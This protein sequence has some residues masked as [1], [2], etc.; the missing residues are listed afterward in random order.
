MSQSI[1][2]VVSEKVET[3]ILIDC[4]HGTNIPV[5]FSKI[6]NICNEDGKLITEDNNPFL[7]ECLE[8]I[9]DKDNKYYIDS[10]DTL[11]TSGIYL[12]IDTKGCQ[13][14]QLYKVEQNSNGD[15][16]AINNKQLEALDTNE[17]EIFWGEF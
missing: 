14:T 11:L 6:P 10:W 3:I 5:I 8:D 13:D 2:E 17:A 15:L 4:A 9:K 7:L 12:W 1:F 16:V